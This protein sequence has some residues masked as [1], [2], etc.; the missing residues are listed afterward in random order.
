MIAGSGSCL[1]N[2]HDHASNLVTPVD[3]SLDMF[4]NVSKSIIDRFLNYFL[5]LGCPVQSQKT[6]EFNC[7]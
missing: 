5:S 4:I 2:A 1:C 7:H 6:V 3:F